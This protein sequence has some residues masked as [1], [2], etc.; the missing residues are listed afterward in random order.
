MSFAEKAHLRDHGA[1]HLA[2][3]SFNTLGGSAAENPCVT[4]L[5]KVFAQNR[6]LK[7]LDCSYNHFTSKNTI[8]LSK[9][10]TK[11]HVLLGLH[12]EGN[13]GWVDSRGF[14]RC[15]QVRRRT[16]SVTNPIHSN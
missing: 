15:T 10:M 6:T 14:L 13:E 3:R 11:N 7:H 2:C 1:H 8:E 16:M 9:E 4:A 12:Y 5:G